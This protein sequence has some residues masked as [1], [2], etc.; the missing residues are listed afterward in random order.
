MA[1]SADITSKSIT[2][3]RDVQISVT[4]TDGISSTFVE[5]YRSTSPD[6]LNQTI[7][8][9]LEA[10]AAADVAIDNVKT[11]PVTISPIVIPDP[12][13]PDPKEALFNTALS[14]VRLFTELVQL[15]ILDPDDSNLIAAIAEAR[16][17]YDPTF[18]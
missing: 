5:V 16:K 7:K 9:R 15:N 3:N 10:L 2:S 11:G 4:Y 18:L 8:N 6:I 13:I 14:Q 17:N 1:W 12:T